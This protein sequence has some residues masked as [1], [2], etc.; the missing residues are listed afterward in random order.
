[1]IVERSERG[2]LTTNA[3]LVTQDWVT[4]SQISTSGQWSVVDNYTIYRRVNMSYTGASVNGEVWYNSMI[5]SGCTNNDYE[6]E[7]YVK[8]YNYGTTT[9][10]YESTWIDNNQEC[11]LWMSARSSSSSNTYELYVRRK[12]DENGNRGYLVPSDMR[13]SVVVFKGVNEYDYEEQT[14][15]ADWF[16]TTSATFVNPMDTYTTII[17]TDYD[18]SSSQY[19]PLLDIPAKIDTAINFAILGFGRIMNFKYI[20]FVVC[21][22]LIVGLVA[23]LIH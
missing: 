11:A 18:I 21:F 22:V 10:R 9:L 4:T 2:V 23:W 17:P 15:P 8:V 20:T 6:L 14:L 12:A 3:Y 19:D 5:F 13:P 7:Y 1:M 16:A